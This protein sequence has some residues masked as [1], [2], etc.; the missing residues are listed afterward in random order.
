[1]KQYKVTIANG[2]YPLSCTCNTIADA[3]ECLRSIANWDSRIEI[4]LDDLMVAL[5]QMYNAICW[6]PSA[7]L[8]R[9]PHL[10]R[11][12]QMPIWIEA[13]LGLAA[14]AL[15]SNSVLAGGEA[16]GVGE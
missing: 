3:Y 6:A 10:R 2:N 13:L 5:V 14:I 1:M 11:R 8:T 9:S 16:G 4:D 7:P 15:G 12:T